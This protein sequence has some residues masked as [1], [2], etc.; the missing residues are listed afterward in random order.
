MEEAWKLSKKLG[1]V[2][3]TIQHFPHYTF[4]GIDNGYAEFFDDGVERFVL[5]RGKHT[6]DVTR[7]TFVKY[8]QF[9][10]DISSIF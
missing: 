4:V 9:K 10:G 2:S 7:K 6:K 1:R 5:L 8:A 3:H